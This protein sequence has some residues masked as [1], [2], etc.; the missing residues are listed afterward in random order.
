MLAMRLVFCTRSR[1]PFPVAKK[2]SRALSLND[3]ITPDDVSQLLTH[4]ELCLTVVGPEPRHWERQLAHGAL[5]FALHAS[6]KLVAFYGD[7]VFQNVAPLGNK[8]LWK[9]HLL[10]STMGYLGGNSTWTSHI[11]I[12]GNKTISTSSSIG[13]GRN[14]RIP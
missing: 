10:A 13:A 12:S 7:I 6:V 8:P 9:A 4:V 11:A 1:C 5:R 2:R 14:G 3:R